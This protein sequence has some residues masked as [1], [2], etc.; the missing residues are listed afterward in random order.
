MR[1][2][3]MQMAHIRN[4]STSKV[5]SVGSNRRSSSNDIGQMGHAIYVP[6]LLPGTSSGYMEGFFN[7]F[8]AEHTNDLVMGFSKDTTQRSSRN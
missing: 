2:G 6:K 1:M 7:A 4:A 5:D 3:N 8:T